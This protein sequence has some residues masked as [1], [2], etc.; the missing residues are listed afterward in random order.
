MAIYF[1]ILKV[2]VFHVKNSKFRLH[3]AI[4]RTFCSTVCIWIYNPRKVFNTIHFPIDL[5]GQYCHRSSITYAHL[6]LK[7]ILSH[8]T[9]HQPL[10]WCTGLITCILV[11]LGAQLSYTTILFLFYLD[12]FLVLKT[13]LPCFVG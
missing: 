1:F 13:S 7:S 12:C 11:S 9:I 3:L 10:H 8:L 6:F 2:H 5:H 4:S